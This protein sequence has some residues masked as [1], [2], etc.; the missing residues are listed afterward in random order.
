MG[1][2]VE[3]RNAQCKLK[4][5]TLNFTA[6]FWRLTPCNLVETHLRWSGTYSGRSVWYI[7]KFL[8]DWTASVPTRQ[9]VQTKIFIFYNYAVGCL[10]F[11]QRRQFRKHLLSPFQD[12]TV[13]TLKIEAPS[14]SRTLF[15]NKPH[16]H[17]YE[18]LM[19]LTQQPCCTG[20]SAFSITLHY[21]Q[22]W[23]TVL[24]VCR[25]TFVQDLIMVC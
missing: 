2:S 8:A 24:C 19:L 5:I 22:M 1:R 7:D 23:Q 4:R 18:D 3:L 20:I 6:V 14:F 15:P 12:R 16:C 25:N 17:I 11:L 13:F 21:N 9:R 10:T